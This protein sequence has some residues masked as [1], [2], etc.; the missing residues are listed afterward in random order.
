MIVF[1]SCFNAFLFLSSVGRF[2]HSGTSTNLALKGPDRLTG[3]L[4]RS[5]HSQAIT[6]ISLGRVLTGS[7]FPEHILWLPPMPCSYFLSSSKGPL[8][9]MHIPS[10]PSVPNTPNILAPSHQSHTTKGA[11]QKWVL[12]K[13]APSGLASTDLRTTPCY[14]IK[15]VAI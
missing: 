11:A 9:S 15:Y 12:Y 6:R 8:S 2:A 13:L 3:F 1:L 7:G 5:V 10:V 4:R 14:I